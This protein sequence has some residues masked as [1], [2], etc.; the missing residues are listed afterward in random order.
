[1]MLVQQT[2]RT[3]TKV[4]SYRLY[5][6]LIKPFQVNSISVCIEWIILIVMELIHQHDEQ[7]WIVLE[8]VEEWQVVE[9]GQDQ[10]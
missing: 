4:Q 10:L 9:A 2:I 3:F 6:G 8:Q 7:L 5:H 1:M